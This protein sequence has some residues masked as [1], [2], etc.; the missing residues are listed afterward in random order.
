GEALVALRD[1]MSVAPMLAESIRVSDDGLTYTFRLRSGARFHNGN[2]VTADDV[3]YAWRNFYLNPDKHWECLPYYDGTGSIKDRTNGAHVIA[4]DATARDTVTFRL[5]APSA[6]F[7]ARMAD[8]ACPPLIFHRDSLKGDTPWATFI[9]TGPYELER[10][11][12]GREVVMRRF[13]DYVPRNEPRDGYAGAKIAYAEEIRLQIMPDREAQLEALKRGDIDVVLD[14][15]DAERRRLEG[16]DGLALHT[17]STINFWNLLIQTTDPLLSDVRMRRAIAQAIDID[18][19]AAVLTDGR[20]SANPSVISANSEFYSDVQQQRQPFD[21]SAARALLREVGYD[22]REVEILANRDEFPEMYRIGV[23]VRSMLRAV[24]INAVLTVLP[25]EEQLD[26]RYRHGTFQLQSFGQGG[27]NHPLLV[28]GKFI[29]P[30]AERARFQWDSDEAFKALRA[31]QTLTD[32]VALQRVF[33]DLHQRML[34]E[35][36]TL[37]LFNFEYHDATRDDV[38][39]FHT[40]AFMRTTFWGVWKEQP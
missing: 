38:R 37:A 11:D 29:G 21:P 16:V 6:L 10:L 17:T 5:A 8:V 25:W 7:L 39:G 14:I 32:R 24:G 22:G 31:A 30:K 3:V 34:E 18:Y 20:Q 33:D 13:R 40:T 9:G 15:Q 2:A 1:D 35:V 12:K 19:I 23:I 4:V 27:R 36:P 28:Y 26:E